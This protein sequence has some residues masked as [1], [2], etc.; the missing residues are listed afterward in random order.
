M[1]ERYMEKVRRVIFF[2]RTRPVHSLGDLPLK[3]EVQSGVDRD[4]AYTAQL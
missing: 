2:A 3:D 4:R 1:F